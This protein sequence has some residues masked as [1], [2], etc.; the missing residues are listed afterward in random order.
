MII[1]DY[2]FDYCTDFES[3]LDDF[4]L[5][6]ADAGFILQRI[7]CDCSLTHYSVYEYSRRYRASRE[8]YEYCCRNFPYNIEAGYPV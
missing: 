3:N 7:D 5:A 6:V 2:I 1:D 4:E 8:C